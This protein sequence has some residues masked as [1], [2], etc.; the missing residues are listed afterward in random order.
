MTQKSVKI[1]GFLVSLIFLYWAFL[2][3]AQSAVIQISGVVFED[4]N[5]N[6]AP[7]S[8]EP[9]LS[10]KTVEL[11]NGPMFPPNTP[12]YCC[13]EPVTT[14]VTNSSGAYVFSGLTIGQG[15]NYRARHVVPSGY[16]RTTDDSK[17]WTSVT[18]N[19]VHNFGIRRDTIIPPP[20]PPGPPPRPRPPPSLIIY[21]VRAINKTL[22]GATVTWETNIPA[23]TQIEICRTNSRC[24][25]STPLISNLVTSHRVNLSNLL[26][27]TRYYYWVKSKAATGSQVVVGYFGFRTRRLDIYDIWV[28]S[29]TTTGARVSW[30]TNLPTTSQLELCIVPRRTIPQRCGNFIPSGS[31]TFANSHRVELSN[32]IPGTTYYYWITARE[33]GG[34]EETMG[35]FGFRTRR[36]YVYNIWASNITSSA[37]TV[38][39]D[40]NVP[41]DGQVE[42]CRTFTPCGNYMPLDSALSLSHKAELSGL[43]P[44]TWY[45]YWVKSKDISGNPISD[46][47]FGFRTRR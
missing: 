46:G 15:E 1:I 26:P 30:T 25:N 39:W 41:T 12:P 31:T 24:G 22:T 20:P 3:S 10:G 14:T 16:V 2:P 35:Y 27:N 43:L 37:A 28:G 29:I 8:G 13:I 44:N 7:D 5:G 38:T 11:Y 47:P 33:A 34:F 19:I 23:D 17:Y 42:F 32:L 45:Y 40:T 4:S 36:I 18:T 9:K 6:G 21:G